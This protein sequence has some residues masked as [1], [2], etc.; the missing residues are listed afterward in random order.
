MTF[1]D[2]AVETASRDRL[3]AL[4]EERLRTLFEG[5]WE[6]NRFYTDKLRAVGFEPRDFGGLDDLAR[7]PFTTK[8][9]LV[10]A[11]AEGGRLSTNCTFPEAAYTRF[12]QTSGTTGE[13][14]R[15]YDTPESWAWWGRC[16]GFVLAGAGLG[17]D[18]RI[19]LPFSFGPFIGFWAAVGGAA[20]VGA[21]MIPGGGQT[22]LQRLA[23]IERLGATAM[24]CT[25]TYALR[26]AE[27]A[28]EEG[29]D[30]ATLPIR[31]TVHAG[32]PGAS[33]PAT[34]TRI[35]KA[36]GAR[37]YDH[38][39]ASEVGAFSFECAPQPGGIHVIESEFVVEV[40]EPGGDRPVAPGERGEL[41]VTNL[42]RL[43]FPVIRYRT[44]DLVEL[45]EEPCGCGRSFR[46]LRGGVIGRADDMVV[47]RGVN[48][49]PAAVEELVRRHD[50]IDEFRV[51]VERRHEM[52]HLRI[53]I[54]C[55]DGLAG[56][57]VAAA[58]VRTF[59]REL[60][61]TPEVVAVPRG[62]LP[63]FELK[64]RRFFV[65]GSP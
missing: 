14:L 48:V 23:L 19:L 41:V 54:E 63:R 29:I 39:G 44:G 3:R 50:G 38:A 16:W 22:S 26:L 60:A 21:M 18:D 52:G 17:P 24:C 15:V 25:P 5:L 32:E 47:V 53:E 4:Q 11:Q 42:G 9:E 28:R 6:R 31:I 51:T 13:P 58:V 57:A 64:A 49:Y 62:T 35:E 59:T 12:H 2:E 7:L 36:W 30:P 40:V 34:K 20:R 8:A 43:G 33:V 45:D 1:F 55:A 37:A 61:L 56:D 65:E 46:R 27:V 10:A